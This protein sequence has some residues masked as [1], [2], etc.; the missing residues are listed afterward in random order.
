M[1]IYGAPLFLCAAGMPDAAAPSGPRPP[2][3]P[4]WCRGTPGRGGLDGRRRPAW[5]RP[6]L[7]RAT[8]G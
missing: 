8:L 5:P 1:G 2:R 3:P 4:S 6:V 7:P